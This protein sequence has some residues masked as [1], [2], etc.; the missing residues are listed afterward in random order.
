MNT[1]SINHSD[2]F[3]SRRKFWKNTKLLLRTSLKD[4]KKKEREQKNT[5]TEA[6]E[7]VNNRKA[8]AIKKVR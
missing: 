5:Y 3:Q 4:T 1:L 8:R 6:K 2:H 7:E